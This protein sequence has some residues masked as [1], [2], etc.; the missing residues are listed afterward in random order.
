[1]ANIEALLLAFAMPGNFSQA[2]R[3]AQGRHSD[4]AAFLCLTIVRPR[5]GN[6]NHQY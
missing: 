1:M 6:C 2:W 3:C 4:V 5:T